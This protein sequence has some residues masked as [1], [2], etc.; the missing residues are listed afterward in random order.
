MRTFWQR[1]RWV[2]VVLGAAVWA[3]VYLEVWVLLRYFPADLPDCASTAMFGC[4][5]W[6]AF[7]VTLLSLPLWY[8]AWSLVLRRRGQGWG[9]ALATP[10]VVSVCSWRLAGLAPDVVPGVLPVLSC[11]VVAATWSAIP[12]RD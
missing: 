8:A 12:T 9:W 2:E 3:G 10:L 5:D 11:V 4:T 1:I 7:G 6:T